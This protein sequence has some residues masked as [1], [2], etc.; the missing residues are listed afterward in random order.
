MDRV[1]QSLWDSYGRVEVIVQTNS[2]IQLTRENVR[3]VTTD[4]DM[5]SMISM[6]NTKYIILGGDLDYINNWTNIERG[7]S[8]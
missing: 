4:L 6:V 7:V 8:F 5:S 2:G 3:A 1:T